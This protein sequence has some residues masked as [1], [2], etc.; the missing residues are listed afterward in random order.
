MKNIYLLFLML[1]IAHFSCKAQVTHLE[2]YYNGQGGIE[3]LYYPN[4]IVLDSSDHNLFI[5]ASN[6]ITHLISDS[7]FNNFSF[8]ESVY[9]SSD[10]IPGLWNVNEIAIHKNNKFIFATGD[11]QLLNFSKNDSTGNIVYKQNFVNNDSMIIGYALLSHIAL[12]EDNHNLY[13]AS[14]HGFDGGILIFDIDSLTGKLTYKRS[15]DDIVDIKSI[16]CSN[17]NKYLYC[18]INGYSGSGLNVY[19][20]IEATDSLKLIQELRAGDNLSSPSKL[21]ESY[22][23]KNLYLCDG[24]SVRVYNINQLEGTL[25]FAQE[26]DITDSFD[27]Y[28]YCKDII[29]NYDDS[30]LYLAGP[31][32]LSVFKRDT[33]TGLLSFLQVI[34]EE[35]FQIESFDGIASIILTGNDSIMYAISEYN[36]SM[37]IFKRSI[38]SGLLTFQ[39]IISDG[40]GKIG[41]LSEAVD[42][43]ASYD[44]KYI[45]TL[46][47]GGSDIIGIW[48]RLADGSLMFIRTIKWNEFPMSGEL[49]GK[50]L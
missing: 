47:Y 5:S 27:G 10:S 31:Y 44:N 21:V 46:A 48:E 32:S 14:T 18:S 29:I 13:L 40:D 22:D 45:Y 3:G 2:S 11:N 28:M 50:W 24:K 30:N 38:Q 39:E 8:V 7:T 37:F 49:I 42:I 25:S 33:S 26:L 16:I 15:I 43:I 35:D 1:I 9:Y 41:G 12:S 34:S 36:N 6:R 17:N 19:E 23:G 20:R 4:F